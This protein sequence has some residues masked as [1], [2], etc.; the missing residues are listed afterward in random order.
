MILVTGAEGY[1]GGTLLPL[2][3]DV[4]TGLEPA[5]CDAVVHLAWCAKPGD[6]Y[7]EEQKRSLQTTIEL[8]EKCRGGD[9]HMV[10][11]STASV[12]GD[13]EDVCDEAH[14]VEP[15]CAYTRAKLAAEKLLQVYFRDRCCIL[16]MGS[17][18]GAGVTKTKTDTIVNAFATIDPIE[19]WNPDC[20]KPVIHVKDAA[21]ILAQAVQQRWKGVFN[22]ARSCHLA[23]DLAVRIGAMRGVEVR[24]VE[25]R[26]GRRSVRLDTKRM[27]AAIRGRQLRTIREAVEDLIRLPR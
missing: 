5:G 20:W 25:D 18:M 10:F 11:A 2:L 9:V 7:A 6:K 14:H 21:E 15:L 1:V 8:A 23:G 19:C 22:V 13:T 3:D 27:Q 26:N 4:V 12:Y 24:E 17:C 16:R